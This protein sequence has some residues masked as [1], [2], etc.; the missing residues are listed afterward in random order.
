[1]KVGE[2]KTAFQK[3][4]LSALSD[5]LNVSE[6]LALVD[7]MVASANETLDANPKDKVCKRETLANLAYIETL[8]GFGIANPF[9]YFQFGVDE[10]TKVK[11]DTLIE[12]RNEAKKAKDFERADA[13]RDEI[14]VLGVVLNDTPQGSFW[15]RLS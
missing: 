1:M 5:D 3:E 8:M 9:E 11:I 4:L 6:A 10:A 14:T 2:D 12:Q 15:E 7:G 13:I